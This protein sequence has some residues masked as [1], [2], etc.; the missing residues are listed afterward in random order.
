MRSYLPFLGVFRIWDLESWLSFGEAEI[1]GA[2][3]DRPFI[4]INSA[5]SADGKISSILRRQVRISGRQDLVRVDRLRASSDA[6]MVGIGTVLA[7]DPKLTIKSDELRSDRVKRGATENPLRIV[8]DSLA[9]TPLNAEVL[10]DGCII[11]VSRAAP[12]QR[13]NPLSKKCQIIVAGDQQ[14]DLAR[15]MGILYEKGV[16][17]MMVE[18]GATLNWSMIRAGLVDEICVYIGNMIIGG[19]QAPS[20]MG[21]E[22]FAP[23]EYPLLELIS[24]DRMDEGILLGWRISQK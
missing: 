23:D 22:G 7:D 3:L 11:A 6:V 19:N 4:F 18:G 14:V 12:A 8:A 1:G 9:R 13:L 2:L 16:N 15:L 5:M 24:F 17:R 10:G 21:G 20:L